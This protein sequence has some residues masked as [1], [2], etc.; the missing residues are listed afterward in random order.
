MTE[1]QGNSA[2]GASQSA[3]PSANYLEWA[4]QGRAHIVLYILAVPLAFLGWQFG[5][6]PAALLIGNFEDQSAVLLQF[7]FLLPAI[8]LLAIVRLF[9]GRPAW[10]V[11]FVTWPPRWR[12]YFI[13]VAIGWLTLII[14][15]ALCIAFYPGYEVTFRGFDAMIAGGLITIALLVIGF[16]IQTGFEELFFRGLVMQAA[17]RVVAWGPLAIIVQALFFAS[18]HASNLQGYGSGWLTVAPYVV[19]GFYLGWVAWRTRSLM[20]PMGL[21]F[22]NNIWLVLLV[23][24]PGDV[25]KSS[26]PFLAPKMPIEFLFADS[27]AQATLVCVFAEL[28]IGHEGRALKTEQV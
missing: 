27:L 21:H 14:L 12:H 17:Y 28:W 10:S 26:A 7:T 6:I 18:L 3:P 5:S 23:N 4:R 1:Q 13:G 16:F 9:F 22:A 2:E 11:A 19:A 20:M 15:D 25:I 8:I 24:T